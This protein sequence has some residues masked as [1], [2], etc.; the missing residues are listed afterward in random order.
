MEAVWPDVIETKKEASRSTT[1]VETQENRK[2]RKEEIDKREEEKKTK[3]M[4]L[5]SEGWSQ[6]S[7]TEEDERRYLFQL[8]TEHL[9]GVCPLVCRF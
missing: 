4:K 2:K 7:E 5:S 3:K 1:P 8:S 6:E 9:C